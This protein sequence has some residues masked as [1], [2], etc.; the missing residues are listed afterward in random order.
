[1]MRAVRAT[2]DSD[3]KGSNDP[4]NRNPGQLPT[5]HDQPS[6]KVYISKK[7]LYRK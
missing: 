3:N 7:Q 2:G 4:P 6:S 1:M 5:E